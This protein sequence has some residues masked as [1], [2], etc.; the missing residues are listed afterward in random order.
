MRTM[1]GACGEHA[2]TEADGRQ[3]LLR[4]LPRSTP[5]QYSRAVLPRSTPSQYSLAVLPRSTPSPAV[6][7][8]SASACQSSPRG[9]GT[10]AA[11]C[12]WRPRRTVKPVVGSCP[13]RARVIRVC[14]CIPPLRAIR[15]H[16]CS[17][18][19]SRACKPNRR[20]RSPAALAAALPRQS[21]RHT[22]ATPISVSRHAPHRPTCVGAR[23]SQSAQRCVGESTPGAGGWADGR[24][25]VC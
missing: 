14:A 7:R 17:G 9:I 1:R 15:M 23:V 5:A 6:G 18:E 21:A 13:R 3:G 25:F 8:R 19:I 2:A 11:P 22:S 4:V 10:T 24:R 12:D 20:D 16:A